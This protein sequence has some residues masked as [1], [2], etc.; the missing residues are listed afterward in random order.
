MQGDEGINVY[1]QIKARGAASE[2]DEGE[3]IIE[4]AEWLAKIKIRVQCKV[5]WG[6]YEYV[7]KITDK[8]GCW[9]ESKEKDSDR[10][11]GS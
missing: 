8:D 2:G 3:I 7:V 4:N 11:E 1:L 5:H 9:L 6:I 10:M